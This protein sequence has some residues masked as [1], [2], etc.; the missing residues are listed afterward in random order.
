[1]LNTNFTAN[2]IYYL[3]GMLN[4]GRISTLKIGEDWKRIGISYI[5]LY[6][7]L[8]IYYGYYII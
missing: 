7:K 2:N 4:N 8:N 3:D 6:K 5:V 1:M